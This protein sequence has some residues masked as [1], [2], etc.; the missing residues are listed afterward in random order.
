[1]LNAT[2]LVDCRNRMC[3]SSAYPTIISSAPANH[4]G[5]LTKRVINDGDVDSNKAVL[6]GWPWKVMCIASDTGHVLSRAFPHGLKL[7]RYGHNWRSILILLDLVK[8]VGKGLFRVNTK[9]GEQRGSNFIGCWAEPMG[10]RA[11]V[12]G[13]SFVATSNFLSQSIPHIN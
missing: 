7:D 3:V 12:Q 13:R 1:M 5:I 6:C 2:S 4:H 9:M 8:R 10:E 11:P